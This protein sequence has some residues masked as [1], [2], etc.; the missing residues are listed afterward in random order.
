MLTNAQLIKATA[1]NKT[2]VA[3]PP[4]DWPK[5][6]GSVDFAEVTG[7]FQKA[8]GLSVDGRFGPMTKAKVSELLSQA[9]PSNYLIAFG[10]RWE[11]PFKVVTWEQ[12]AFW[13][14]YGSG[15]FRWRQNPTIDLFVMHWD[16]VFSSRQCHTGL[17]RPARDAS[18]HLY[19]D[20]DAEATVYQAYDL[21]HVRTWN[22]GSN[23]NCNDRNV[24]CEGNNRVIKEDQ[25]ADNPRPLINDLPVNGNPKREHLDWYPEQKRRWVQLADAVVKIT[26]IPRQVPK[27]PQWESFYKGD[28]KD[29]AGSV[30]RGMLDAR[31]LKEFRGVAGHFHFEEMKI[32]PGTELFDHFIAAGY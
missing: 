28:D 18:V 9:R 4:K 25:S 3:T 13:S 20:G 19:L 29:P 5:L 31:G 24:G 12:D 14:G 10:K 27:R 11:V 1:Y 15:N 17:N 6:P 16:V 30:V 2:N 7:R 21:G 8:H 26:G 22:A 23:G 32:D